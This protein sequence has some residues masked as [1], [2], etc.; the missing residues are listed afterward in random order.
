MRRAERCTGGASTRV[1]RDTRRAGEPAA[2][3]TPSSTAASGHNTAG[4][5]SRSRG[6]IQCAEPVLKVRIPRPRRSAN[7]RAAQLS[8]DGSPGSCREYRRK[9]AIKRPR[10]R[11][12][13]RWRAK[14]G[15]W[16]SMIGKCEAIMEELYQ[17]RAVKRRA[18]GCGR[19]E[20]SRF[21]RGACTSGAHAGAQSRLRCRERRYFKFGPGRKAVQSSNSGR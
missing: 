21:G 20:L 16:F 10:F 7:P 1:V 2:L 15:Y 19:A 5:S 12:P 6:L 14:F 17:S 13:A 3:S 18:Q 8:A 4:H 11:S 9:T